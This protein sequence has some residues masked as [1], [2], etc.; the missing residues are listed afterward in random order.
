MTRA[1]RGAAPMF[2]IVAAACGSA[3]AASWPHDRSGDVGDL[4]AWV[5]SVVESTMRE[6]RIPGAA[7]VVVHDGRIALS[8]GYGVADVGT[9]SPVSV[10]STVFRVGSVTK[11][12]TALAVMRLVDRGALALDAPISRYLDGEYVA[13]PGGEPVRVWH[14]LTHSGGYDQVGLRRQAPGAEDR[15][16]LEDFVRREARPVRPPGRVGVYDT[17]GITVAGH[18]VERVSGLE[19]RD[20]V[21]REVFDVLGMRDSWVEVPETRRAALA[22][23]YGIEDGQLRPQPY[24]WYVT[25]P[26]SSVDATVADMGRLLTAVLGDG[27]GLLSPATMARVRTERQLAYGGMG[28]FSWGFWEARRG[29]YRVLHHGGIMAGYSSE[30]YL[31]PERRAGFFV[32][33][34]RDPETG[35]PARLRDRLADLLHD[36]VVPQ[37]DAPSRLPERP[38]PVDPQAYAGAYGGTVACFTCDDGEGWPM[39]TFVVSAEAP[40]VLSMYGGTA[41]LLAVDSLAFISERTGN[42]VR[43]LTDS[44]GR[45]RYMVQ[46][47]NSFARLDDALLDEVLGDGWR[48]GPAHPLIAR[49]HFANEEWPAAARAYAALAEQRPTNGRYAFNLGFAQL[50]NRRWARGE[51][52]FRRALELGQWPAWSQYYIASAHAGAGDAAAAWESLDR[53]VALGFADANLLRAEPWWAPY[54]DTAEYAAVLQ[55]LTARR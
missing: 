16:S 44:A 14:L 53:A 1:G 30:L 42:E 48:D 5:D 55:R 34:N 36:R 29:G 17:Y 32:A 12:V 38:V 41:R 4:E 47:P 26:A 13:G 52:A 11:V 37:R 7:V 20:H 9:G 27:G 50:Q 19:F 21:R 6:D 54:R 23:G 28:A 46:G 43:F 39:P 25:L 51:A 31:V 8:K 22:T 10:D 3:G 35:P 2:A 45:V 24:E 18:L 33:Y 40:G 15:P 49:V